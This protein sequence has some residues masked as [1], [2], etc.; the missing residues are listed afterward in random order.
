MFARHFE[1]RH[2]SGAAVRAR[3]TAARLKDT[4][5]VPGSTM[6][7][8]VAETIERLRSDHRHI[9]RRREREKL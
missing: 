9:A 1:A 2:R 7:N 5:D 8:E 3:H 4:G 6:W